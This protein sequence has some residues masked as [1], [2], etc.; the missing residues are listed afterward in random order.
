MKEGEHISLLIQ[1]AINGRPYIDNEE[2][3]N[4]RTFI[5]LLQERLEKISSHKQ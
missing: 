1:V 3:E 5:K 2:E 4:I